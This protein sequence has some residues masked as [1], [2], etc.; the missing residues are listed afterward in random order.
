MSRRNWLRTLFAVRYLRRSQLLF[1]IWRRVVQPRLDQSMGP[2]TAPP[3]PAAVS[4]QFLNHERTFPA[5][6]LDWQPAGASR[7]WVYNLHY[8]SFLHDEERSVEERQALIAHWVAA[9]PRGFGPGWEPYPVSLRLV[10]WCLWE[11]RQP[12]SLSAAAITS[13]QEQAHWLCQRLEKHILANHYLEN[14]KALVFAGVLLDCRHAER[15]L[16]TGQRELGRQLA[17]Q[18]LP[19]GGHYERSPSYHCLLLDGLLDLLELDQKRPGR[20]KP[21]LIAAVRGCAQRGLALLSDIE[22]PGD[23]YPLF[24]DSALDSAPRPSV[25]HARARELGLTYP[26]MNGNRLIAYPG[27]GIFGLH[28]PGRQNL[29]IKCGPVGPDYQPGHTH[30]DMLS[31]EW[32]VEGQ[33]II[34]DTGVY[35]YQ[36]GELRHYVRSTAAHNTVSVEGAEQSEIW[37]EF[38]VGRRAQVLAASVERRPGGVVFRGAIKAFP[39]AG[40]LRHQRQIDVYE[41]ATEWHLDVCDEIYGSAWR[42][43]STRLLLHPDITVVQQ[44]HGYELHR[45]GVRLGRLDVEAGVA[46]TVVSAPYC[47]EFGLRR[48]A[49][50]IVM[51]RSSALPTRIDYR[52]HIHKNIMKGQG[53]RTAQEQ[54]PLKAVFSS[55]ARQEESE[56]ISVGGSEGRQRGA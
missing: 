55:R 16:I 23:R 8:F 10:N 25:L 7:L 5:G 27:F 29:A 42:E 38:R 52:L 2:A 20:L 33:P 21:A 4:F 47:P 26:S 36:L 43:V 48:E 51:T 35:E 28:D 24:N 17:E 49:W 32:M 13:A 15:W 54:S 44:E 19:D 30:C 53:L 34:V 41:G 39:A 56:S 45:E 37:A 22:L 6:S 18:F 9:N 1:W 12:G 31:Y 40:W 46:L 14:L 11:L 3:Y 50:Q